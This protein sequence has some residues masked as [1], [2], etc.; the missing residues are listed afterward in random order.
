MK[1]ITIIAAISVCCMAFVSFSN[2]AKIAVEV[3]YP[4]GYREWTHVKSMLI[5]SKD[6]KQDH[7]RGYHHIY[8]NEKAME[9]YKTGKFPNGSVIVADFIEMSEM[10]VG[11][12][13]G[14]R[15]F[16]DVMIKNTDRYKDTGGW[17]YEEFDGDSK[18]K[19]LVTQIK[20]GITCY[21]CHALKAEKDY[22][23]STY[24]E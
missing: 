7:S 20:A 23:Y 12:A 1:K 15:K 8:A 11:I 6:P 5:S 19:R 13:E 4:E 18:E 14:K 16:I 17:G 9:G 2:Q 21:N 10:E 22:V 24:R 3:P